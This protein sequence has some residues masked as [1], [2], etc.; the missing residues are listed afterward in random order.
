MSNVSDLYEPGLRHPDPNPTDFTEG[1]TSPT[2]SAYPDSINPLNLV[3]RGDLVTINGAGTPGA[4][5]AYVKQSE[6]Q[7]AGGTNALIEFADGVWSIIIDL[8]ILYQASEFPFAWTVVGG[9]EPAPSG[10]FQ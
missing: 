5:G 2:T 9:A 1:S 6:S 10:A 8:Q 4:N 7:Y 3:K